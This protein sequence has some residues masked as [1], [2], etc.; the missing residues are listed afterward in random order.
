MNDKTARDIVKAFAEVL[1]RDDLEPLD[2]VPSALPESLLRYPKNL[3][4]RSIALLL[5]EETDMDR[6][7]ILEE[8]YLFL[9]NFISDQDY[10]LFYFYDKSTDDIAQSQN[11]ERKPLNLPSKAEVMKKAQ[12]TNQRLRERWEQAL[13][14]IKVF[15]RIMGLPDD[16]S[17]LISRVS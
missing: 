6:R 11:L 16:L 4:R 10:K 13:E 9:D 8:S 14:E 3:I 15:R 5:L 17:D 7:Q 2:S 1:D 12:R